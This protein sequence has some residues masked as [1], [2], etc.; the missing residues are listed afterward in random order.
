MH[1]CLIS[2]TVIVLT[3]CHQSDPA[4]RCGAGQE[5]LAGA[6]VSLKVDEVLRYTIR[7]IS[8]LEHTAE[9]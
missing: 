9:I 7:Y 1:I 5:H 2:S 6:T 3:K 4:M 8:R